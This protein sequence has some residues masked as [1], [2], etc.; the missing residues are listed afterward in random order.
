MNGKMY[1][2]ASMQMEINIAKHT[3]FELTN[4]EV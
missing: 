2:H 3:I 4:P 1:G